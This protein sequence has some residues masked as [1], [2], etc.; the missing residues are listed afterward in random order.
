ML[1]SHFS[2]VSTGFFGPGPHWGTYVPHAPCR[3]PLHMNPLY[4]KI[5]GTPM[6]KDL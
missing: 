5:Q 1:M 3:P 6:P 2:S 4:C